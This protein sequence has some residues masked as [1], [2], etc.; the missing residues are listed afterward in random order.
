MSKITPQAARRC[1]TKT[2][3]EQLAAVRVQIAQES[4]HAAEV[5]ADRIDGN[6]DWGDVSAAFAADRTHAYKKGYE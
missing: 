1:E 2:M 4:E 3:A 6:G 5:I